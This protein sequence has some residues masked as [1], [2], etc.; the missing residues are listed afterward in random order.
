MSYPLTG[1]LSGQ[2]WAQDWSCTTTG[3]IGPRHLQQEIFR[4]PGLLSLQQE[5]ERKE[6]EQLEKEQAEEAREDMV[7]RGRKNQKLGSGSELS[8]EE[9]IGE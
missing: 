9:K 1:V 4:S 2:G 8:Q 7:T 6:K 3:T 5:E